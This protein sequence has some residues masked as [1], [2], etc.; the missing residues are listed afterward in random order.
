MAP[1]FIE[2]GF[3][4]RIEYDAWVTA[5]CPANPKSVYAEPKKMGPIV[6]GMAISHNVAP[7]AM[8]ALDHGGDFEI[9]NIMK[10]EQNTPEM[11]KVNPWHQIPNMTDTLTGLDLG[12]SG[13]I[14]RYIGNKYAPEKYG[15]DCA[16][17]K[18]KIDW[19]LDW[20][21]TNFSKNFGSLRRQ[22]KSA[23]MHVQRSPTLLIGSRST[24][25]IWYPVAGFGPAPA[26]QKA[27]N[28]KTI[29][30][31]A[32]FEAQFLCGPGKS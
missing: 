18:A 12:E 2:T 26:D 11:L 6:R 29:E 10:G 17:K 28:A 8:L 7:C 32:K 13:A 22:T 31:L 4:T 15:L 5:G 16:V 21:A 3:N 27:E 19:A 9:M 25:S 1:L 24:A 14:I 23:M 30:N 20:C